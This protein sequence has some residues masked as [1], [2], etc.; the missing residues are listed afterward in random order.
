MRVATRGIGVYVDETT[1]NQ[2]VRL[3]G[4]RGRAVD[5]GQPTVVDF[6]GSQP[7]Q[8]NQRLDENR[9][10]TFKHFEPHVMTSEEGI[11]EVDL[12]VVVNC[13]VT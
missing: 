1:G 3:N 6:Q 7:Q 10:S 4:A 11:L 5:V 9:Q 13:Y 2:Y 12:V 8:H